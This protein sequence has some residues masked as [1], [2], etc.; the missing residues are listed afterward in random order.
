MKKNGHKVS[1]STPEKM[2]RPLFEIRVSP[3][4]GRGAFALRRI[5]KGTRIIEYTGDRVS[6]TE[7]DRR[8]ADN[9][10]VHRHILVFVVDSNTCIDAGRHGNE[11]RFINH[12]CDPNC[13]TIE[14]HGRI[15]IQAIRNIQPGV[16][17]SYDYNLTGSRPR[18]KQ[19]KAEY[20]CH[21]GAPNCRG[22]M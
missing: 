3:I 11:A 2:R 10:K 7:A 8:Y 16:E 9:G 5:R 22:Y 18:T 17:L 12:S 14:D 19:E 15:F 20:A 21:C 4:E 1:Q 13:E 6:H